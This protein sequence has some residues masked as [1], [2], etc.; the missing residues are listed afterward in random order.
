M[1]GGAR[2]IPERKPM[3]SASSHPDVDQAIMPSQHAELIVDGVIFERSTIRTSGEL[4]AKLTG[5]QF[6]SDEEPSSKFVQ[7]LDFMSIVSLVN[8]SVG[9]AILVKDHLGQTTQEGF[10]GQAIADAEEQ[11]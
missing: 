7:W 4:F 3:S 2:R 10:I 1:G 9:Q 8:L 5:E 11:I 6:L